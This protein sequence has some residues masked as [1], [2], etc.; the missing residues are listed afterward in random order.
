MIH[1]NNDF[2]IQ[3]KKAT[4]L[5]PILLLNNFV[6]FILHQFSGF[7]QPKRAYLTCCVI[8]EK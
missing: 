1:F 8:L 5:K 4:F 2:T 7:F 6:K 3:L